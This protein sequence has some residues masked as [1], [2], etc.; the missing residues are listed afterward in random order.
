MNDTH[1]IQTRMLPRG[2]M[3]GRVV[4][5]ITT[6]SHD[7]CM[8]RMTTRKSL[9]N[10]DKNGRRGGKSRGEDEEEETRNTEKAREKNNK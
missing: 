1:I 9:S 3:H 5:T 10:R 2:A 7:S 4:H 6:V 8:M